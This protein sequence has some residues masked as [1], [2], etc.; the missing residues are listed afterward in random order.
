VRDRRY[1]WLYERQKQPVKQYILERFAGEL[2]DELRG[3]PPPDLEWES[4][5]LRRRWQAGAEGPPR[6]AVVRCALALARL[7]L[8]REFEAVERSLEDDGGGALRSDGERAAAHLLL[9]LLTER[10]L[11][12]KEHAEGAHLTRDDLVAALGLVE[13]ALFRVTLA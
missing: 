9:R 5:A 7:D 8:Q 2:A 12:L 11:S 3:W 6:E 4:E 10:C 1:D 13:R